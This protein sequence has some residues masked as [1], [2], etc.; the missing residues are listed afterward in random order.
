MLSWKT[1]FWKMEGKKQQ[2]I[3]D[4]DYLRRKQSN[5]ISDIEP[6]YF[7]PVLSYS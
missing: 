7:A 2:Q 3:T 5:I 1:F 6:L 4:S